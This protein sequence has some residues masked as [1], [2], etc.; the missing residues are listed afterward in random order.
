MA[1][2]PEHSDQL[3]ETVLDVIA[4]IIVSFVVPV[5]WGIFLFGIGGQ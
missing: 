3:I 1:D 5:S 4:F 2:K